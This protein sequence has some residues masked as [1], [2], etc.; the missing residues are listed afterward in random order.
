MINKCIL[1]CSLVLLA[2]GFGSCGSDDPSPQTGTFK[3][4]LTDA[5]AAYDAVNITF[6]EISAHIDNSWV[7]VHGEEQ[8][9]NLLDW[10][11]GKTITLG[12]AELGPGKYTQIRLMVTSAT[13]VDA[14]QMYN[15]TIPSA[16]QTGLKVNIKGDI[17]AGS[18]YEVILDFDA[19]KS[20][21]KTGNGQ[22]KL[23]PVIRA[24]TR[25][26]T[27]SISGMVSNFSDSPRAY[28]A[29]NGSDVTS[30]A[31]DEVNGEFRLSF[32]DPGNYDV[33]IEDSKGKKFQQ[34]TVSVTAGSDHS[35]GTVT[36]Q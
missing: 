12:Q 30:T 33:R 14:G 4:S 20:I 18:T 16:E 23:Q 25:A 28:A 3:I 13:V 17:L 15:V 10:N 9:V 19:E 5:P 35:I 22:Y 31:V 26:L 7:L 6:A 24:T 21:N 2:A 27:G 36:L 34:S 1:L 32:L 8:T 29:Q 11:N